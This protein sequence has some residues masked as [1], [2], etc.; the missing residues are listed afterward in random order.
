[1]TTLLA[2]AFALCVKV[3]NFHWHVS[4]SH[5]MTGSPKWR[6]GR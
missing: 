2:D 4:G 6:R 3:K 1:L 5:A